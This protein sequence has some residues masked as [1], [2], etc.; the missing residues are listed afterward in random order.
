MIDVDG[1]VERAPAVRSSAIRCALVSRMLYHTELVVD[2]PQAD[3]CSPGS[4][5]APT[6]V[7]LMVAGSVPTG[8]APASASLAGAGGGAGAEP[9]PA[10]LAADANAIAAARTSETLNA[11]TVPF[12]ERRRASIRSDYAARRR[13]FCRSP[14]P[15][16]SPTLSDMPKALH[17]TRLALVAAAAIALALA[18]ALAVAL[19]GSG[20]GGSKPSGAASTA[21]TESGFDGAALPAGVPAPSFTLSD[22]SGRGVS[23]G[24]YRG[25]VVVL[26]FLYSTCG[27]TCVVIAQQIRGALNELQE[28]HARAPAVLIVSADP[29]ADA[30][31]RVRRFLAEVSLTGRVQYLTGTHAQ[32]QPVWRAYRVRPAS[33]GRAAFDEYAS[34]LLVDARG[35]ER[36]LFQ[37]EELTPEGISHDIVKLDRRSQP[38]PDTLAAR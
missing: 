29:A 8:C 21:P 2:T 20:G 18:A 5:V 4:V 16:L 9:S 33:D 27:A 37:S 30:P 25:R 12:A 31:A 13:L 6:V 1:G 24:E 17:P 14:E 23:L 3:C 19:L 26:T 10:A 15:R 32:L 35:A 38:S 34:V 28:Q 11:T 36:V 7:P 22:Q